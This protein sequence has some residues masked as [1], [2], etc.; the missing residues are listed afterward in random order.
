MP[1]YQFTYQQ[2]ESSEG[3]A[4]ADAELVRL[5]RNCTAK[6]YAPYSHFRVGAALRLEG[7][8]V[9]QGVNIENASYPVGICA[10][11]SALS[12]A[13]SQ[14][15]EARMEVMAISIM[16]PQGGPHQ[17]AFPCGMCRQFLSEC[18]DRNGAP[19][20]LLL[21]GQSGSVVEIGSVKDLLPFH[22]SGS[23]LPS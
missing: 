5:A 8:T 2:H 23:D 15:P 18:E 3:L 20:R 12:S 19:I 22:F 14:F 13:I 7:G 9:L 10:E 4:A 16:D 11:R 1:V 17:P 21:S 6:A